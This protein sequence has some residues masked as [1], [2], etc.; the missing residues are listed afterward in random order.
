MIMLIMEMMVMPLFQVLDH[1]CKENLT[2]R[3]EKKCATR[4]VK[5]VNSIA[6]IVDSLTLK[7]NKSKCTNLKKV[8]IS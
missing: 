2:Y 3:I 6:I 7:I 4:D 1:V 8:N 5:E